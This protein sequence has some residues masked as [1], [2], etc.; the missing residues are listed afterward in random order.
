MRLLAF[1]KDGVATLAVRRGDEIVDL[2]I[3]A[4]DLPRDIPALLDER[5]QGLR[6]REIRARR[7]P[8]DP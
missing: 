2:S 1:D 7:V 3:A 4:P 6:R 5:H 8:G